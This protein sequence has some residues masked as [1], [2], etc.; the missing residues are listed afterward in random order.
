[1]RVARDTITRASRTS[2]DVYDASHRAP[3]DTEPC[4]SARKSTRTDLESDRS[5]I[6]WRARYRDSSYKDRSLCRS[7]VTLFWTAGNHVPALIDAREC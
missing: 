5:F 4:D 7:G 6:D 2:R 1:M 3:L